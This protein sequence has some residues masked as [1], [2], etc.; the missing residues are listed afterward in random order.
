M[1]IIPEQKRDNLVEIT[2]RMIYSHISLSLEEHYKIL[3]VWN[4]ILI[5][6]KKVELSKKA[7]EV[8]GT[9]TGLNRSA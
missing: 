3:I 7:R 6:W 1:G 5:V 9:L 2:S 4:V 8:P